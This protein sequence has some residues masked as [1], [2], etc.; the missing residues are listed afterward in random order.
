MHTHDVN[1]GCTQRAKMDAIEIGGEGDVDDD[2]CMGQVKNDH[3]E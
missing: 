2:A 3:L 1:T